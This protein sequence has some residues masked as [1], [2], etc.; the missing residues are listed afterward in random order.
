MLDKVLWNKIQNFELGDEY[1]DYDFVLRLAKENY[2]TIDFTNKAILEYKKFMYLVAKSELMLSPSPIIDI[3]WHQHLI[4]TQS[5]AQFCHILGKFINHVPSTLKLNEEKRFA[6]AKQTTQQLYSQFFGNQPIEIWKN[7]SMYDSLKLPKARTH[8]RTVL[9]T[10]ILGLFC[11]IIPGVYSIGE[12]IRVIPNPYF[13]LLYILFSIISF[14]LL[15]IFNKAKVNQFIK[16][17]SPNS[18]INYLEPIE[19]I[20]LKYDYTDS[21]HALTNELIIHNKI[22][23]KTNYEISIHEDFLP[24][25]WFEISFINRIKNSKKAV[26]YPD[27]LKYFSNKPYFLNLLNFKKALSKYY[28]KSKP[29]VFLFKVNLIVLG[30]LFYIGILRFVIGTINDKPTTYLVITLFFLL[31]MIVI[32]LIDLDKKFI[33]KTTYIFENSKTVSHNNKPEIWNYFLS[34]SLHPLFVPVFDHVNKSDS[35]SSCGSSC[36]GGG[37]SC[38][39]GCG[40]CGGGGD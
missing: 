32:F 22:E 40:G 1:S 17:L 35:N 8:L 2:W 13:L 39:G 29:Y 4:F 31:G 38:G 9:F 24:Q 23:I 14:L 30:I 21:I 12:L 5:Y 3:V 7:S 15:H 26:F 18:F 6:Q 33:R 37:G 27:I 10:V 25:N 19:L 20:C 28:S 11:A 36:S 16:N 34:K